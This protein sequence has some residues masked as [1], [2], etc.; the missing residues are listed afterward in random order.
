MSSTL[1]KPKALARKGTSQTRV[2]ATRL[3]RAAQLRV[4]LKPLSVSRLPRW[5]RM[6][7]L[8]KISAMLMV[9]KAMVVPSA[10]SVI[11]QTPDSM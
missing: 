10:L 5:E 8:W 4:L 1:V 6:L 2:V 7:K 11:V 9:T 3:P